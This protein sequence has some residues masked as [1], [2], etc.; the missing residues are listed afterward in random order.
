MIACANFFPVDCMYWWNN[1]IQ[2]NVE[3]VIIAKTLKENFKIIKDEVKK[4]HSY[5]IPC[6]CMFDSEDDEDYSDWINKEV[7]RG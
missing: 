3:I 6:I 2:D 1:K 7:K 5:D 4:L